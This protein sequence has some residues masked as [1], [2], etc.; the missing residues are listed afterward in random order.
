[1]RCLHGRSESK[2]AMKRH[3]T[4]GK[5]SPPCFIGSLPACLPKGKGGLA[6]DG[7]PLFA[8]AADCTGVAMTHQSNRCA[9]PDA[10][11]VHKRC[12]CMMRAPYRHAG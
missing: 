4:Q 12:A 1:M 6:G 10:K 11:R 2:V 5:C 3:L 9:P 8:Y 7:N